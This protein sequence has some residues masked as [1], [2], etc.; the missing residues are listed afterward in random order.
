MNFTVGLVLGRAERRTGKI[1]ASK[2]QHKI[3][4]GLMLKNFAYLGA[5]LVWTG[6]TVAQA[7]VLWL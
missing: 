4:F 1:R 2:N 3:L 5:L 7:S 6:L